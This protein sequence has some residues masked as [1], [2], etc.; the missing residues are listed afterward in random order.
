VASRLPYCVTIAQDPD[1]SR[2]SRALLRFDLA[3]GHPHPPGYPLFL[4][5]GALFH[6]LGSPPP[7]ALSLVSALSLGG[8]VALFARW[9]APR[10]GPLPTVLGAALL[11]VI[12]L[13]TVLSARPLSDMLGAALAWCALAAATRPPPAARRV[14][15]LAALVALVRVSTLA[16][17]VPA[18]AFALVRDRR[19]APSALALFVALVALGY[20]PVVAATG[21][22]RFVAALTT[23]ATGHFER[24]GGSVVTHPDL[25]TRVRAL[26]WT[27]WTHL[28]GGGWSDRPTHLFVSGAIVLAVCVVGVATSR[29]P[30]PGA[31]VVAVSAAL[32]LAW[33]FFGQNILWS[34]RHLLPLAPLAAFAFAH[35]ASTLSRRWPRAAPIVLAL[36]VTPL[37]V[38][39][40]RLS[41]VQRDQCPPTVAVARWLA[42]HA[43]PDHD[44]VATAQLGPWLRALV[45]RHQIVDV[46]GG[47][48]VARIRPATTGTVLVT[49]EVRG[50]YESGGR[51]RA[52]FVRDRYVT[53]ALY[54]VAIIERPR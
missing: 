10:V 13:S 29:P 35:G 36:T 24:F 43:D 52:R 32:Y 11:A 23:H 3:Q 28:L 47:S 33:V 5:L 49:S 8:L 48:D 39:S 20:A 40:V 37:A 34:P 12:P 22:A 18:L 21:P 1:G 50:A 45:P 26:L 2:F 42:A 17:C 14:A 9:C 54:D 7:L 4:A 53:P 6:R 30:T 15:A 38:E 51:V 31:R 25:I 27:L 16:L 19:R 46:G 41:R 44:V